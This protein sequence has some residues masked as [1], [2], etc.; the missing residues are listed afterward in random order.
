MKQ[1]ENEYG[2]PF[3]SREAA[4]N[5]STVICSKGKE[6][7]NGKEVLS[8]KKTVD[9]LISCNED[10]LEGSGLYLKMNMIIKIYD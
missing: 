8:R 4:K 9:H 2:R 5:K 1:I 7:H 3:L 6:R 10:M